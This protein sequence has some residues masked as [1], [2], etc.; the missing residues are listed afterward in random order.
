MALSRDFFPAWG[1]S[2]PK[3]VVLL[4]KWAIGGTGAVGTQ[5]GSMM[6]LTRNSTGNYTVQCLGSGGVSASPKN[7]MNC[8]VQLYNSDTD[9]TNDT[10]AHF[11][12][13]LAIDDTAGTVSFLTVDEGGVTRDPPS[14]AVISVKLTARL[15]S[16]R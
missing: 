5:T 4:S 12:K 13:M 2:E 11:V 15:S 10:D 14:G 9:P 16:A 8:S 6:S 1:N 3:T 7:I